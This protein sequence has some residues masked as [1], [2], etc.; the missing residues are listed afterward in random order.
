MASVYTHSLYALSHLHLCLNVC[1]GGQAIK[2][3]ME[4]LPLGSLKEYLPRNKSKVN[5]STLIS[6]SIQICKVTQPLFTA[7]DLT[8]T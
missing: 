7:L 1:T 3:I 5:L 4:Y 8:H 2:L 6:Y